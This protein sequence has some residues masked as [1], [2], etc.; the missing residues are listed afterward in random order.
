MAVNGVCLTVTDLNSNR[1]FTAD[2]MPETVRRT[3]LYRLQPG[4]P[5]NLETDI[6][7]RYVEKMLD[8][9]SGEGGGKDAS[10]AGKGGRSEQAGNPAVLQGS[11]AEL[12][13]DFLQK[14]GF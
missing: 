7:A 5:V 12:T 11:T 10:A 14:N 3:T 4:D 13:R 9:N 6:L 8:L 2:V 1:G